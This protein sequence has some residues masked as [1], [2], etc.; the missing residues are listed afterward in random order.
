R[1]AVHRTRPTRDP[2]TATRGAPTGLLPA[3]AAGPAGLHIA[4]THSGRRDPTSQARRAGDGPAVPPAGTGDDHGHAAG[5]DPH[6][7]AGPVPPTRTTAHHQ[8][9]LRRQPDQPAGNT[10]TYTEDSEDTVT[11]RSEPEEFSARIPADVDRPDEILFG[12][13]A[14]QV[15]VL[16]VVAV[17]LLAA[18]QATRTVLPPV[19]VGA[20][21]VVLAAAAVTLVAGRRDG[22]GLDQLLAAAV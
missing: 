11:R 21:V 20:A 19:V 12:L 10:A 2:G 1:G 3:P 6:P 16:A 4:D 9:A 5:T 22:L 18:W 13:T 14:R 8:P 7:G 17:G 15:A